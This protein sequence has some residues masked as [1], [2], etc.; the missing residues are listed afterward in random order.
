M[1]IKSPVSLQAQRTK[2]IER[3]HEKSNAKMKNADLHFGSIFASS[4]NSTA[5]STATI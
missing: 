5:D 3:D 1:E 4:G 2:Q